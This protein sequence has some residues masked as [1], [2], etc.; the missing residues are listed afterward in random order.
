MS[1]LLA[2]GKFKFTIFKFT[3]F[4][5]E[6]FHLQG[7]IHRDQMVRAV[8]PNGSPSVCGERER[9]VV[10]PWLGMGGRVCVSVEMAAVLQD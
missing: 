7:L 6:G 9:K 8:A 4:G 5:L 10:P 1:K 3:V 2:T